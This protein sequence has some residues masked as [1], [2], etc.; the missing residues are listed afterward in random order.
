MISVSQGHL[1]A[2]DAVTAGEIIDGYR[3]L[4]T[5]AHRRGVRSSGDHLHPNDAGYAA[6]A[7]AVPRTLFGA[8]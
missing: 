3:K 7:A 4:I 6:S 1:P 5:K 8:R 2:T